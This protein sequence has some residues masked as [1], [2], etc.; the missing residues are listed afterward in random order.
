MINKLRIEDHGIYLR[1]LLAMDVNQEYLSWLKNPLVNA[2]LEIRFNLPTCIEDLQAFIKQMNDCTDS[3]FLGIFKKED[4][5][6]I[7]NIKLGPINQDHSYAEVGF[8]IGDPAEWGK[9]YAVR[10]IQLITDY[11]FLQ[12]N[13]VKVTAGCYEHNYGS[14]RALLK[15]GFQEEG[16][17][18]LKYEVNG[19]RQDGIRFG[20]LSPA[21][22]KL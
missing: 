3:L 4:N 20:K 8:L 6:H 2:H 13:L 1:S 15:A 12:L 21:I 7:G 14:R 10:A 19:V 16:R 22:Q 17:E 18:I 5:K 11:A 9:G